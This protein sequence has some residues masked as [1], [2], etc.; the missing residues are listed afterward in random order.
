MLRI[1]NS[2]VNTY[3]I[4]TWLSVARKGNENRSNTHYGFKIDQRKDDEEAQYIEQI[5]QELLPGEEASSSAQPPGPALDCS[6]LAWMLRAWCA[7]YS[8]SGRANLWFLPTWCFSSCGLWGGTGSWFG[9]SLLKP[10]CNFGIIW[11]DRAIEVLVSFL[12]GSAPGLLNQEED[13]FQFQNYFC[14]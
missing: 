10:S 4:H 9:R 2:E 11:A 5:K 8:R 1:G 14:V 13:V 7:A 12:Q 6:L 3:Y